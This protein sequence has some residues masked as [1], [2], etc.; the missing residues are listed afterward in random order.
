MMSKPRTYEIELRYQL[1]TDKVVKQKDN[2]TVWI[3]SHLKNQ[4]EPDHSVRL[5]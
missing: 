4:T 1:F 3:Y 2:I 5:M